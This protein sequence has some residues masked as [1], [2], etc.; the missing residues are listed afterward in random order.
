MG[1]K[2]TVLQHDVLNPMVDHV[3]IA[4][5]MYQDRGVIPIGMTRSA[6][7]AGAWG[8]FVTRLTQHEYT[9]N[10]Y[11][12]TRAETMLLLDQIRAEVGD[13]AHG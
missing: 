11:G 1:D 8:V 7:C 9:L 12:F 4:I 2:M 5:T 10:T 13:K 3:E 6:E